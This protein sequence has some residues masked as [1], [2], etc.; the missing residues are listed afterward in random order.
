MKKILFLFLISFMTI[1]TAKAENTFY[2]GEKVNDMYIESINGNDI[3][4]GAP[5]LLHRSDGSVVYCINPFKMMNT[6]DAYKSYD[7]NDPIFNLTDDQLNKLN[8]IASFGYGYKEHNDIKWFGITQYMMWKSL[9]FADVYFTDTYYGS[10]VEKYVDEVNEL[11]NL[12]NNYYKLPSFANQ[13]FEYDPNTNYESI[14]INNVLNN[15]E[16]KESNINASISDNKLII[17]T[18]VSGNYNIT[19]VR[20]NPV[21]RD[22]VLY[23]LDGAQALLYPGKINDVTFSISIEVNCGT[24]TINKFDSENKDRLEAALEGSIFG[25]YIDNTLISELVTNDKGIASVDN[26]PLGN[27]TVKELTSSRGY[28]KDTNTYKVT[29]SKSNK[30]IVINSNSKIIEGNLIINKYFGG[31]NDYKLDENAIFEVYYNNKLI[32][33]LNNPSKE[34][35]EYGTYLVKQVSGKK[36]YDLIN[37]FNVSITEEKDYKYDFY[38]DKTDEIKA[39]EELLK[40]RE[41]SLNK[42]QQELINLQEQVE[43]EKNELINLKNEISKKE[44]E[45]DSQKEELK[46]KEESLVK[47]E[48]EIKSQQEH[49]EKLKEEIS[50][51]SALLDI[52]KEEFLKQEEELNKLKSELDFMKEELN[53]KEDDLKKIEDNIKK[54]EDELSKTKKELES[55]S[56]KLE[57]KEKSLIQLEYSINNKETELNKVKEQLESLSNELKER[58]DYINNK[59]K[60]LN[61]KEDKLI[62]LENKIV[63]ENDVLV[64]EVPNTYKKSHNK[65][66]SI[67]LMIIGG[68]F[69]IYSMK[70]VTIH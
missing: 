51:D 58:E 36:Y 3:H 56:S 43:Q 41:E 63:E 70:K 65:I 14:D 28:K 25:I 12:V 38:T 46:L 60:E 61:E 69:I 4:N 9:G 17:N 40:Q 64:V 24:I 66:I 23:D 62:K 8:I 57:E 27:Y 52:K 6:T 29:I 35:F 22:Y 20:K 26:L 50:N 33:T 34:K 21:N 48:N 32:K 19:F 2:L 18:S 10:R 16:I 67:I 37:D 55:L 31:N 1:L 54:K 13:K 15:Y 53:Q 47:I 59:E 45:L 11:E 30:D 49:L 44:E 39:Y 68:I 7:Y 42:R 5:F